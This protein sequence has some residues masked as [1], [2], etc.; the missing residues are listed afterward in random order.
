MTKEE[1]RQMEEEFEY[2]LRGQG[3]PEDG[4]ATPV[5]L[6]II[7][8]ALMISLMVSNKQRECTSNNELNNTVNK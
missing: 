4:C 5:F 6:M 7:I 8:A 2:E 1:I 3:D